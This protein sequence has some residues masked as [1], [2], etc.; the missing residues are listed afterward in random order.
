MSRLTGSYYKQRAN[1]LLAMSV[2]RTVRY[3]HAD[4][5]VPVTLAGSYAIERCD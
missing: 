1:S 2:D 4:S 5:A 3:F